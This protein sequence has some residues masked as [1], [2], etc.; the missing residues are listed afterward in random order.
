MVD[1]VSALKCRI[2]LY[3]RAAERLRNQAW[4]Y[5]LALYSESFV[6]DSIV[7]DLTDLLRRIETEGY[8]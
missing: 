1:I 3:K 4:K 7:E 2:D 8:K 6:Y 5:G